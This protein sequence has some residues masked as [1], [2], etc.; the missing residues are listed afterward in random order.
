ML[1]RLHSV[2]LEGIAG[3]ICEVEVDVARGGLEKS[4]IVGLPD[5]AVKESTERVRSAI[6]NSGYKYPRTQSVVNLAPADVKKAG[7]A[8]DLPIALGMLIGQGVLV[9]PDINDIIILGELALDGRVRSVNGVLSMAM[10]AAAS[11]F[12]R[13]IVPLE[14]AKE[15]AVVKEMEVYAIGTLTQAAGF[16]AGQLPIETTAVDIERLFEVSSDYPVDFADVKGQQSVKRA[17]T[18]AAA[19]GHNIMMIGPPGAGKTMLAQRLATILPS[20]SL[21]ES[22]E[23]TQIYSSVGLL[24][25]DK[26]LMATRPV[27][28]PHHSASGPALIGGGSTPRPGEL[29]LAHFGIL[30]LDEFVVIVSRAKKSIKFPAQFMLVAAMNPCPCGYFGSYSRGCKCSPGQIARY[31]SKVSG[32]LVDR[33]DIHI[34]VPAISFGKLRSKSG[35]LDSATMRQAVV[36]A[37]NIQAKRFDSANGLTNSRMTHK[38]TEKMC[39]LDSA[40]ELILKQ[41]MME[42]GLSARAHDK[43]CKVARTIAD[44]CGTEKIAPEHVAEAISYRK[45]DRKL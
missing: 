39:S 26:A 45:L 6:V 40:G 36:A 7:P 5:T 31:L 24:D 19:G 9:N 32:P 20:L 4:V 13:M 21:E 43:I 34:E 23:T 11:G 25:K 27:R 18:V 22:L 2:T 30:F 10:T 28:T 41:A 44:L 37:R 16:I 15:A 35:Q 1:A 29:S 3:V 8:F 38:Q 42:L 12:R 14:N 17:L 33:I